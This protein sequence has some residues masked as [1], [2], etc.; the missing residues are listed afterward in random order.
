MKFV[1]TITLTSTKKNR[2]LILR[3]SVPSASF[4]RRNVDE[5]A[6]IGKFSK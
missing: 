1:K 5:S 3:A 4:M 6:S 2:G